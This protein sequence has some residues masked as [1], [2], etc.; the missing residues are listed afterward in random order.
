MPPTLLVLNI[1]KEGYIED[2]AILVEDYT[3]I[4]NFYNA[5]DKEELYTY[6]IYS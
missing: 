2:L 4:K 5:L 3:R 6:S 1:N